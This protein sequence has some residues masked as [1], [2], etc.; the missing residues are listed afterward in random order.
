MKASISVVSALAVSALGLLCCTA[1][2]FDRI[3]G[4]DFASRSEVIAQHAMAATSHPLAT[5]IALDVMKQGGNAIDAAIAANAALGLMEPTGNGIG[6]DLYAIVWDAKTEQLYG[7][8]GSG[9]SPLGLSYDQVAAELERMG[10]TDLP[11]H[12]M[13]P[14][15]VPGAIDGWFELHEKF[16]ALP[17]QQILQPS[18]DYAE[19]GFPVTELIAYY[20]NRSVPLLSPQPGD[21]VGTFTIDGQA[22]RKGQIFKNPALGATYRALAADGRDAFYR[23]ELTRVMDR[24]MR[25][26]GGY[27]RYEDFDQHT[28]TWV[29]PVSVNYKGYELWELPPNGQGI[30][31]LQM[32]QILKNFDL[33]AMGF[34]S[35]ESI[36]TMVEAKKLAFEDRAKFYADSDFSQQPIAGLISEA[37]GRERAKL[38]GERAAQRVDA[39]NPHLYEGDTIYL[40]T[41]DKDGNMVSL[42]QS[43][44]RGMG[45]G[46]VVPGLGFVFQDRGQ[47]FS[48]DKNHANVYEPGK[49]P[50]NTIIPAFITQGGKPLISYGVMGGAMQPQGHV[51]ILVNM[52]DYGMNLQE[53]GDAA[54]WQ[55]LGSTEPTDGQAM[56]LKNGGYIEV[57]QGVPYSTVRELMQRG[58][59][60]RYGLGGY[61]G[62]QAIMRDHANGV[63]I[64]AS[65]SRKDGQ[66]AGY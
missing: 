14:I 63:Y 40:T 34:N 3:T 50:F 57:E 22:P 8:N 51:Q 28:S 38:I 15:S 49:R 36:H 41:A 45:S 65:E 43:N 19:Q 35:A 16:G 61:G 53:A 1:L 62:Y 13:L 5:Q 48:M 25:E 30:A 18:I 20:W 2:A 55:H 4:H 64:G 46:V 60:V 23:G 21:F 33:A 58:H 47:M 31:A 27:L 26:N 24:F 32:L 54:R 12:G 6:G 42:I 17:M 44:Y 10:R 59:Q 66:A 11:P 37:Y 29:E 56:Y 39:G 52:V 9:R 7:L